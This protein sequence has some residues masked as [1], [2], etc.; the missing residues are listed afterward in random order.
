MALQSSN[1]LPVNYFVGIKIV[2]V[3][4]SLAVQLSDSSNRCKYT[5]KNHGKMKS[6]SYHKVAAQAEWQLRQVRL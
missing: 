6:G 3:R 4:G 2:A 1:K 5:G